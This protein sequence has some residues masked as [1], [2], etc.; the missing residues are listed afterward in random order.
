M[1]RRRKRRRTRRKGKVK[2]NRVLQINAHRAIG[3]IACFV[4][5]YNEF[6]VFP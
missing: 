1:G 5:A 6:V 4:V 3:L 2:K